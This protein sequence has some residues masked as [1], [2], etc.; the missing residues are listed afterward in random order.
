MDP[1]LGPASRSLPRASRRGS[2]RLGRAAPRSPVDGQPAQSVLARAGVYVGLSG[3]PPNGRRSRDSQ[4]GMGRR[5][6]LF[7]RDHARA[8]VLERHGLGADTDGAHLAQG[9]IFRSAFRGGRWLVGSMKARSPCS[10]QTA[11]GGGARLDRAHVSRA[12][13]RFDD[14]LARSAASRHAAELWPWPRGADETAALRSRPIFRAAGAGRFALA[15][16]FASW[17]RR[18]VAVYSPMHWKSAFCPPPRRSRSWRS[19]T[20]R[21][22]PRAHGRN[23]RFPVRFDG[24]LTQRLDRRGR[25]DLTPGDGVLPRRGRSSSDSGCVP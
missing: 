14:L 24:E 19:G 16:A 2:R 8:R 1:T 6:A 11:C 22:R 20:T 7:R 17:R 9:T 12:S 25:P 23:R 4:R 18:I 15:L 13:G 5:R 10:R 21:T 3:A